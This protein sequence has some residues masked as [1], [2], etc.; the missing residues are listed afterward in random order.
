MDCMK[1][2]IKSLVAKVEMAENHALGEIQNL[3][4]EIHMKEFK[5]LLASKEQKLQKLFFAINKMKEEKKKNQEQDG[6]RGE[7]IG[8]G[9][10]DDSVYEENLRL[11]IY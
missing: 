10:K 3:A 5:G 1:V 9:E 11:L 4:S 7:N 6:K 2:K 8:H